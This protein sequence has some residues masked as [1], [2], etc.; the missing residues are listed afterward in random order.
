MD[1]ICKIDGCTRV[2]WAR[3]YCDAH[4]KRFR[5]AGFASNFD[6]GSEIRS[7]VNVNNMSRTAIYKTWESMIRRCHDKKNRAYRLYGERG[8]YV[9]QRW[10][11]FLSFYDDMGEKPSSKYSL[12]R[13]D[14]NKGYS[15]ENCRW[16]TSAQQAQNRRM[17]P[18]NTSGHTGISLE[19]GK[20][21][22][23]NFERDGKRI[24][25]NFTSKSEAIEFRRKL[26]R[27]YQKI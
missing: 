6:H 5:R 20:Y 22:R 24:R 12:D 3:R 23:V 18:R 4:Y 27:D 16:A 25:K 9:C 21:W 8:I 2:V 19:S 11:S 14:N 7:L 13:I 17:N 15:P 26:E 10:G 1:K